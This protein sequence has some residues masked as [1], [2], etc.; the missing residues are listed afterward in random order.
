MTLPSMKRTVEMRLFG[1][2]FADEKKTQDREPS[3]AYARNRRE[4]ERQFNAKTPRAQR[5]AKEDE[6]REAAFVAKDPIRGLVVP[7][8]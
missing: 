8:Y 7:P 2:D 6:N 3:A 5:I 4:E 1:E